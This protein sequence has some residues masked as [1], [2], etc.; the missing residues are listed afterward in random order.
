MAMPMN[1]F[2]EDNEVFNVFGANH[3]NINRD[4]D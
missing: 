2:L 3:R 1:N 4:R